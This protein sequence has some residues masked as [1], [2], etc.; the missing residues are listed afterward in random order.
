MSPRNSLAEARRTRERIVQRSVD[1]ASV[2]GLSGL[3]L[4]RLAGDLGM[5]KSGLLGHF[6]SKE[7]LQ[8]AA[9][10]QGA[11]IFD[12]EVWRPAAGAAPGLPRLRAVCAAWISYLERGVFPGGCLFVSSTFEFDGRGGPVLALLRRQ[13]RAWAGRLTGELR[14]A[15]ARGELPPETD[16]EQLV[17]ELYGVM[18][19]LNHTLQLSADPAAV[20]RAERAVDRLLPQP[21][22]GPS[23]K[24]A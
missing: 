9:L 12:R 14:S 19:S 24:L 11:V 23:E 5:S 3:T 2:E 7:A 21:A 20:T 10:R 4:G 16:P 15:V 6:G 22:G 17:F 1:V 18:M 8:L 13:F